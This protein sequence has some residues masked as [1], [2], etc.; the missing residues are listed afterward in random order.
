[1]CA[2]VNFESKLLLTLCYQTLKDIAALTYREYQR[3]N[4]IALPN[5]TNFLFNSIGF[6]LIGLHCRVHSRCFLIP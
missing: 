3:V 1:M 4:K 5:K 2:S 6:V